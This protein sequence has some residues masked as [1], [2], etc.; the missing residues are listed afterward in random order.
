ML[1]I[2]IFRSA[3]M[4]QNVRKGY[5]KGVSENCGKRAIEILE[6]MVIKDERVRSA[7][8]SLLKRIF[9]QPTAANMGKPGG[10]PYH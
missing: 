4:Q 1:S 9:S 2:D 5:I 6:N 8:F 7:A 3:I 10:M